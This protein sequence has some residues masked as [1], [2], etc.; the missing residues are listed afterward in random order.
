MWGR[1]YESDKI[2][3]SSEAEQSYSVTQSFTG[4]EAYLAIHFESFGNCLEESEGGN[5]NFCPKKDESE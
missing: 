1:T 4:T 2:S 3:D 5:G